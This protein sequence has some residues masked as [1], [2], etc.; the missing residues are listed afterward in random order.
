MC[1]I[2]GFFHTQWRRDESP[3]IILRMLGMIEHRG[4]DEQG[5]YFD[6]LLALGAARLAII[7]GPTGQQPLADERQRFWIAY[8]GEVY[9]YLEL[10]EELQALGHRFH[11]RSD[12]EVVLEAWKAWGPSTPERFNGGFAFAIYD[13]AEGVLALGRDRWGKRPLYYSAVGGTLVFASEMKAFLEYPG[14]QFRW[15]PHRLRSLFTLWTP[16]PDETPFQ[17]VHQLLPGTCMLVSRNGRR[18]VR[19]SDRDG[20]HHE[21]ETPPDGVPSIAR[22]LLSDS[23]RLRLRSD[24]PVGTYLSGGLDSAIVTRLVLEQSSQAVQTFS[25]AF[26]EAAFDESSDQAGVSRYL[27]TQHSSLLVRAH[28]IG[29]RFPDAI[30][31]AEVPVFRSAFVPMFLLSRLVREAGLKVVLTGEGADEVFLGYDIFKEASL[32][33]RWHTLT[34]DQRHAAL[35]GLYG[36]ERHFQPGNAAALAA[37]FAEHSH[38]PHGDLFS[39]EMRFANGRL[40]QRLL[41]GEV[42]QPSA[43]IEGLMRQDPEFASRDLLSRAQILEFVTLLAGYLL[44]TQ[45]DRMALAH[46]VENRCPFLDPRVVSWANSLAVGERLKDGAMEKWILRR[47]FTD[48]LPREVVE[49]RKQPYRAPDAEAF[50]GATRPEYL[51]D[52]LSERALAAIGVLDVSFANRFVTKMRSLTANRV[53]PRECQALMLLLSLSILDR[54]FVHRQFPRVPT[55]ARLVRAHDGSRRPAEP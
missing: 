6:D 15:D 22:S 42:W 16:L 44:S 4:P 41:G 10:R 1:G 37:V 13:R 35:A 32:R 18:V 27:G 2:A 7:D 19:Y 24:V 39:H 47:A 12:T 29:D 55:V 46:G 54:Y 25:V 43:L 3:P 20:S 36:Y 48:A 51:E 9:N 50:L 31:F 8:N 40:A 5:Y 28:E 45:G 34:T 26:D 33:Q 30:W 23:V 21:G 52:V 14:M 11:T 17:G 53:S 49:K 38:A